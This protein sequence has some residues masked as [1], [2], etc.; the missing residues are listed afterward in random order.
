LPLLVYLLEVLSIKRSVTVKD[1]ARGY[2]ESAWRTVW[3]MIQGE[4]MA[5]TNVAARSVVVILSFVSLI[6][7]A[8]YTANLA[9]FL[10]LKS[11]GSI[12][13]IFDLQ[14]MS[15]STV[16]VYQPRFLNRYGLRTIEA[17]ISSYDDIRAEAGDVAAGMLAAFLIDREV[18][19]YYVA[20]W[21]DCALRLLPQ[22]TEPFDYGLAF[23][24]STPQD[25]VSAFSLAIMKL[26]ED[27][28]IQ[29]IGDVYLLSNSPCLT[30]DLGN[31][32]IAQLSFGQVYGLWVLLGASIFLG[33]ILMASKRYWKW[34]RNPNWGRVGNDGDAG[35]DW[36]NSLP[37]MTTATSGELARKFERGDSRETRKSDLYRI[38][39]H[40]HDIDT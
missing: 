12:N 8:S 32:E 17:T 1:S 4:T 21:P 20:T 7:S 23:G 37:S 14:G 27:G 3:V 40:F 9:A 31:E 26:T 24:T 11:Y 34:R 28:T 15:V 25:I 10:T 19:Q 38:E 16:E 29:S 30:D 39:S 35:E 22:I 18:A 5:V 13:S 6:L 33:T 36:S 2:N